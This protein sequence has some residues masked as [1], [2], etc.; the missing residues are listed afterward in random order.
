MCSGKEM[1]LTLN[2]D[3]R[4]GRDSGNFVVRIMWF[5]C[6]SN[7]ALLDINRGRS[8]SITVLSICCRMPVEHQLS[9]FYRL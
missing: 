2:G 3:I 8:L 1:F 7:L 6:L 4:S 9:E 5:K